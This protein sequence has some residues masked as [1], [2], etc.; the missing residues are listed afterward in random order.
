MTKENPMNDLLRLA[1]HPLRG[2][3]AD[4]TTSRNPVT[5]EGVECQLSVGIHRIP[6]ELPHSTGLELRKLCRS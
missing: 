4:I 3:V 1:N 5:P 6:A 2:N